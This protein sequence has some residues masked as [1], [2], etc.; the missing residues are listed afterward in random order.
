M[1]LYNLTLIQEATTLGSLTTVA[2][3]LTDGMLYVGLIVALFLI[4]QISMRRHNF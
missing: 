2:N 4:I 3:S 1:A